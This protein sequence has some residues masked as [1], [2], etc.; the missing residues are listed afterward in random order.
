[1]SN[2]EYLKS[3]KEFAAFADA[4]IEAEQSIAASTSLCA[5]GCRK[6]AELAVKWLYSADKNLTQPFNDNF[7]ALIYNPAFIDTVDDAIMGKLKYIIKL[8]NFAAHTNKAVT[9]REAVLAL[10][11]LFDFI[12]FVDYCYG[13]D[14]ED[15]S[16][17]ETL[18]SRESGDKISKAEFER[19]KSELESKGGEREKLLGEVERLRAEMEA[20]KA[21]NQASR[22]FSAKSI[23]EAETR[24][25][26]I[27]VDLQSV[28]WTFGQDCLI[29]YPVTG[30]PITDRNPQGNGKADY[31]LFGDNGKPIA[32]VEAKRTARDPKEGK[33]QAKE[34]AD[35]IEKMAGLR[36]LIFYTNGYETWFWD[37]IYYPERKVYSVFS[38]Q[39]IQ[40][41]VNR[42]GLRKSF[43]R[44]E[45]KD[46]IT[47]RPYQKIATQ[48]IVDEFSNAR[49]KGL[50]VMA[51]GTGKT[52]T[53]V[54]LV[55]VLS[56]HGWITNILF[57]ADRKELVKQAKQAF[58]RHMPNLSACNLLH[59][60][61]DEN[62]T[63]R[64][65]FSTYPTIMNAINDA[66][67]DDGR[68]LFT[69]AHFDLIV[70]DEAH[71]SIFKKYRAIFSYFDA[72]VVG[73]TATPR[74]DVDKSTYDFF[75]LEKNMPTY[76][77]GYE[78]AVAEGYLCDYH[79]IERL[80]QIPLQ[81]ILLNELP[82]EERQALE[83]VF[84][85]DED[86]P[87]FIPAEAINK[88]FFNIDTCRRVITDLMQKGLKVEGGDR[89]GKTIIFAKNHRHAQFIEEQFDALYPQYR[90]EFARVIDNYEERAESL[91]ANFKQTGKYPQIAISVDM[92]DTGIDVPEILNLVYFKLVLS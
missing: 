63:D 13:K 19:L 48:R 33:Q 25:S 38:K 51:T 76:A 7:S 68:K 79:C 64:A 32:V 55:D 14:Y 6:S 88:I 75:D 52:R 3:K 50:L 5:L 54:S 10:G 87:D 21:K 67:T 47:D 41:I 65:I 37:D 85:G 83:D 2:F 49:R 69:P 92:L 34:Y 15:R 70:V 82:E 73:L 4:C 16:F 30:M 9:Y 53:V 81:G 62:P 58:N 84:E 61:N 77:Y 78:T 1:L 71:R 29:E 27:D 89:L 17:D 90:G 56:R 35:C 12:Q 24:K 45:I 57:L 43:D 59:R 72:M 18:L 11:N 44:L 39:D 36:P 28:G 22:S 42:R 26:L 74:N 46:D 20:L 60:E 23:S 8:G 80:Y 66:R 91:L 40:R 31:V 86:A